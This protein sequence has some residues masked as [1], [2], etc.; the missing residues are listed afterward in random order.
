MIEN[1]EEIKN[2]EVLERSFLG[3]TLFEYIS[4][5]AIFIVLFLVI[6]IIERVLLARL[7]KENGRVGKGSVKKLLID[8]VLSIKTGFYLYL[9][10]F[11]SLSVLTVPDSL[12]KFLQIILAAWV[13]FRI[14]MGV[15]MFVDWFLNRKLLDGADPGTEVAAK[16][17]GT[18]IKALLW[19]FAI[20]LLL[21]NF[22]VEV[23]SLIAGLGIGGL[24]IA[25]ALQNV[26]A[27]L[28]SSF[29]I[30]F[31]KPFTIGDFIIIGE[32]MGTVEKIGIKTTRIRALQGEEIVV[33]N[34]ELTNIRVHN[35]KK[36]EK[37]R[38][39][40]EFGVVYGT[41][42]EKMKKIPEMI[43]EIIDKKEIA[44]FD[45][46]HFKGFGDSALEFEVA[47]YVL[48]ANFMD[49]RNVH[50]EILLDIKSQFKGEGID[51]AFPTRTVHLFNK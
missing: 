9:A 51:M 5:L 27:D 28:F 18:L 22:G 8:F 21:S 17:I 49:Y 7:E 15:Q 34:N 25:F 12:M 29:A 23:T 30:Y 4:F 38:A 44:E 24:A 48:S 45:R 3:N 35:F 6:K 13:T 43:K 36:L 16:N 46:A 41:A 39:V 10:L 1:I 42:D 26:L 50:Q 40:F 33:S 32:Q 2:L 11:I 20:L 37:R 31:D 47:Y 14:M 19:V